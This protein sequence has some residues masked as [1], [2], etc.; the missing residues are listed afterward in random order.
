M[1]RWIFLFANPLD[2]HRYIR[3]HLVCGGKI[4]STLS[5]QDRDSKRLNNFIKKLLRSDGVFVLRLI[6]FNT[7]SL[8]ANEYICALWEKCLEEQ[9]FDSPPIDV[10]TPTTEMDENDIKQPNKI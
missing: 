1:L 9:D 2:Q 7:D 6:D 5:K 4:S 10:M 8:T 3:R